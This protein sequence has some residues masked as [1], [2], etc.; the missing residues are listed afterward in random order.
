[1]DIRHLFL[2][3]RQRLL[4]QESGYLKAFGIPIRTTHRLLWALKS[5]MSKTGGH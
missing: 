2:L 1:M 4:L 5:R 3:R